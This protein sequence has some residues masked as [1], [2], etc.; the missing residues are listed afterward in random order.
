MN[1]LEKYGFN[2]E[3]VNPNFE[4]L[5]IKAENYKEVVSS[6]D[7]QE[8]EKNNG[9]NRNRINKRKINSNNNNQ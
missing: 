8:K 7:E 5:E 1:F 6:S 3:I 2:I 4:I 9:E